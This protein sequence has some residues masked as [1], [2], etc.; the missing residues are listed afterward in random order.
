VSGAGERAG[1][2]RSWLVR[3][4]ALVVARD[5]GT[6]PPA[7]VGWL[8]TRCGRD[9]DRAGY[10]TSCRQCGRWESVSVFRLGP[11]RARYWCQRCG[12]VVRLPDRAALRPVDQLRDQPAAAGVP[13]PR[14]AGSVDSAGPDATGPDAAGL[15]EVMPAAMRRWA[16][17]RSRRPLT[18]D[19]LDKSTVY[20]LYREWDARPD[21][22]AVLP[23]FSMVVGALHES[24]YHTDLAG[25]G[26]AGGEE[27]AG[28]LG[29]RLEHAR[30]WLALRG[31]DLC[32]IHSR[33]PAGGLA[34]PDPAA[35]AA[36]IA[37]LRAG[38]RPDPLAARAARAAAFGTDGGPGLPALLRVYPV[39]ELLAALAGYLASGE[40]PLRADVLAR[41]AAPL[42]GGT[43]ETG[44]AGVA[45][46][47]TGGDR[48]ADG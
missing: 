25:R 17:A 44:A 31:R 42:A 12:A 46:A 10:A 8:L 4:V 36:A 1:Q 43:G 47:A 16:Q 22:G 19:R 9:P 5:P 13:A 33:V 27:V 29:E 7:P 28:A 35:V 39:G 48:P 24:C 30:R 6:R 11:R 23:A 32:W 38:E 21:A 14:P 41:L 26:L 37:A 45:G 20:Q 18:L 40:R 3:A 2:R 34:E 15:A